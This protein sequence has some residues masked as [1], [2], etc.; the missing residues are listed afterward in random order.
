[1]LLGDAVSL[2]DVIVQLSALHVLEYE[3]DAIL[4]LEDFVDVDD[5]GVIESDQHLYLILG[6][7]EI[8]LVELGCKDL[9][10]VLAH[11]SLHRAT[12][13]V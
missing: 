10:A 4:L 9:L 8:C 13:A 6:S 2:P 5:V 3:D 7:E 12:R 1:M 11:C